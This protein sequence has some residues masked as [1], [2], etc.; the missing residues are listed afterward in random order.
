MGFTAPESDVSGFTAPQDEVEKPSF[1]RRAMGAVSDAAAMPLDVPHTGIPLKEAA[2]GLGGV[3]DA[4]Q[5]GAGDAGAAVA[6]KVARAGYP[7]LATAAGF[8]SGMVP[9]AVS[10]AADFAKG[11]VPTKVGDIAAILATEGMGAGLGAALPVAKNLLAQQPVS[12]VAMLAVDAAKNIGIP[13]SLTEVANTKAFSSLGAMLRKYPMTAG[14]MDA[15]DQARNDALTAARQRILDMFTPAKGRPDLGA[16]ASQQGAAA[17]ADIDAQR[18]A[19]YAEK[20]AALPTVTSPAENVTTTGRLPAP[21]LPE[22]TAGKLAETA[23]SMKAGA[24]SLDRSL[25][26][27]ADAALVGPDAVRPTQAE[28]QQATDK[29][30]VDRQPV[31]DAAQAVINSKGGEPLVKGPA[32][33]IAQKLASENLDAASEKLLKD[34]IKG[35]ALQLLRDKPEAAKMFS[36]EIQAALAGSDKMSLT[37]LNSQIDELS[38]EL[39]KSKTL[40]GG[41][42]TPE[43]RQ[44]LNLKSALEGVRKDF[45][46]NHGGEAAQRYAIADAFHG[47]Y[48]DTFRNQKIRGLFGADPSGTVDKILSGGNPDDIRRLMTAVGPQGAPQVKSA[49]MDKVFGPATINATDAS[50]QLVKQVNIP[51]MADVADRMSQYGPALRGVL[52]PQEMA[53]WTQFAR[54]G[55]EPAF[56]RSQFENRMRALVASKNDSQIANAMLGGDALT[57]QA[58]KKFLDPATFDDFRS[59]LANEILSGNGLNNLG[60]YS[61]EFLGTYFTPGEIE[62]MRTVGQAQRLLPG[63]TDLAKAPVAKANAAIQFPTILGSLAT[64]AGAILGEMANRGITGTA[65]GATIGGVFTIG[66]RQLAKLYTTPAGQQILTTLMRIDKVDPRLPQ[67]LTRLVQMGYLQHSAATDLRINPRTVSVPDP[68]MAPI[69]GRMPQT[70]P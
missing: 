56:L 66:S 31:I 46:M 58:G 41:D 51:M 32:Y 4:T 25:Y 67:V 70:A 16:Q 33:T 61:K 19:A 62:G 52:T 49:L 5:T 35:P 57:A 6:Q 68:S 23:T 12:N 7:K 30:M 9:E 2:E 14:V 24:K 36:P 69:G 21:G 20:R 13:L 37:Q 59:Q 3:A 47:D 29:I 38:T 55:A 28:I 11:M 65:V 43:A 10:T 34:N 26:A 18:G 44:L 39:A 45:F 48:V 40:S 63:F 22:A 17:M 8:V 53:Q 60:K 42:F 54:T 64:G 27:H 15:F 50:G 1:V